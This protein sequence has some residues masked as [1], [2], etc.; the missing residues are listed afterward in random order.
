MPIDPR[1]FFTTHGNEFEKNGMSTE[2]SYFRFV[3]FFGGLHMIWS[4]RGERLAPES[5]A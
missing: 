4:F 5:V 3:A 1:N 2:A